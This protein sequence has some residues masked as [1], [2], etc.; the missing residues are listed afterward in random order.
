MFPPSTTSPPVSDAIRAL[1]EG[2]LVGLPTETVYGLAADATNAAAVASVYAAKGRPA[3]NPLISHVPDAEAAR[4][5]GVFENR[6]DALAKA[7]W[8]GPLTLVVPVSRATSVVP[9]AR[10][11]L[12]TI[13]LRVPAHPIARAVIEG[14]GRPVAAPSANR[15]GHVS[16]TTAAHVSA[17]LGDRVALVI[18]G[19][20]SVRGLES[21]VVGLVDGTARLL[22]PGAIERAAIE[23]L[24][25]P[26]GPATDGENRPL[27]PG[28]LARHYA[29]RT[30]LRLDAVDVRPGEVVLA[31]GGLPQGAGGLD[32]SPSRDTVEAAANLY[33]HLRALDALG[34][35]TI[36]VAPIPAEGLGEAIRDRLVRA[37]RG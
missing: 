18:D 17:D 2:R 19:G 27:S 11:G 12:D 10:A 37:A 14:L 22:R 21:T 28:L 8:P 4:C 32:L 9:L 31:F 25:G 7:F 1:R 6:A 23:A 16:P 35:T 29:T 26:L 30:P 3:F 36:A 24:T 13:A 34:A 5:Q 20:P 33:A 15:S